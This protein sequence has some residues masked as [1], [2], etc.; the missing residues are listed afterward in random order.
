MNHYSDSRHRYLRLPEI[1][2]RIEISR[3]G[4]R[5]RGTAHYAD[6]LQVLVKWDDGSSSSLRVGRDE[7]RILNGGAV[8]WLRCVGCG[9]R[10][11]DPAERWR[12]YMTGDDPPQPVAYCPDCARREFED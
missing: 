8:L 7:F 2:G 9:A 12:L 10:W 3:S 6:Y 4:T 5:R 1:G 11:S